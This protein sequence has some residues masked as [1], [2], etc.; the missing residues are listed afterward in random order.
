M[1]RNILDDVIEVIKNIFT[2]REKKLVPVR[3]PANNGKRPVPNK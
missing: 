1:N 3:V 2:P